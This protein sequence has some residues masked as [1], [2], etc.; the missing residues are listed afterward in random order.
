MLGGRGGK[1]A[2]GFW[3]QVMTPDY[4]AFRVAHLVA[5]VEDP[6]ATELVDEVGRAGGER[7]QVAEHGQDARRH[8]Q[9][10]SEQHG[11]GE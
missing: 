10:Q 11:G 3:F 4:S 6:D 1:G 8:Q 5:A 9:G 2:K 7:R